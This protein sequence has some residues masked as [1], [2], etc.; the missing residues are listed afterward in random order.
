MK[1][2][3]SKKILFLSLLLGVSL[4][5]SACLDFDL[6]E[7][8][9]DSPAIN[10]LDIPDQAL[11][12]C[13]SDHDYEYVFQVVTL[14]CDWMGIED[15]TGIDNFTVLTDL[16]LSNNIFTSIAPLSG[17]TN[18]FVLNLIESKIADFTPLSTLT[19][20]DSLFLGNSFFLDIAPLAGLN[21]LTNLGL[22]AHWDVGATRLTSMTPLANLTNLV[23]L[24][25]NNHLISDL[26]PLA[27]MA[28]LTELFLGGN[29][30]GSSGLTS[31]AALSGLTALT[32]LFIGGN[33]IA[34]FTALDNLPNLTRILAGFNSGVTVTADLV[35]ITSRTGLIELGLAGFGGILNDITFL[36]NYNTLTYLA[37]NS[38]AITDLTPVSGHTGLTD[39]IL[40]WNNGAFTDLSPLSGLTNM[41]T[42]DVSGNGLTSIASLSGLT[43]LQNLRFSSNSVTDIS[44][45]SG[46]TL[47]TSL[48]MSNNPVSGFTPVSGLTNLQF[49]DLT[50][51]GLTELSQV[52]N[53]SS[54]CSLNVSLNTGLTNISGI[55]GL[56]NLCEFYASGT[57]LRNILALQ[58]KIKLTNVELSNTPITDITALSSL[59]NLSTLYLGN[60]VGSAAITAGV[61]NL[62]NLTNL[63]Y[64]DLTNQCNILTSDQSYLELNFGIGFV[65][66]GCSISAAAQG[67]IGSPK[68]FLPVTSGFSSFLKSGVVDTTTSYYSLDIPPLSSVTVYIHSMTDDVD[69]VGYGADST[70]TTSPG[71]S[72]NTGFTPDALVIT[73]DRIG[74]AYFTVTGSK[75]SGGAA[76]AIEVFEGP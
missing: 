1:T 14:A 45:V 69:L 12:N 71:T 55:S 46:M 13:L 72:A 57:P 61:S 59:P 28:D 19:G 7:P 4:G 62:T 54:L 17:M 37:L 34:D 18:L 2:N 22:W 8:V 41:Q 53:M 6:G 16:S 67:T 33:G 66:G 48:S 56:A 36:N 3:K 44:V 9:P 47:L 26:T 74:M 63:S 21:S 23:S 10:T 30:D 49:L 70:F 38:N 58:G 35:P 60:A 43:T 68:A 32:T 73:T 52:A 5:L 29:Y 27:G 11:L 75:T 15:L 24:N 65:V 20:L 31:I 25:L 76:F 40:S 64:L 39:L 42:L 51:T 50:N